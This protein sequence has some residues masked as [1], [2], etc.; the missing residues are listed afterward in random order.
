[1]TEQTKNNNNQNNHFFE[2]NFAYVTGEGDV[3][4]KETKLFKER[5]LATVEPD[6]AKEQVEAFEK[7]FLEL[8]S[9][10]DAFFE[11]AKKS[12]GE[13]LDKLKSDFD[14]LVKKAIETDAIGDFEN[15]IANAKEKFEQVTASE[16]ESITEDVK[17]ED[18][19][20][21]QESAE[22]EA[23]RTVDAAGQEPEDE[24]DGPDK[25]EAVS[26]RKSVV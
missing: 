21:Q 13:G 24:T 6:M 26:D 5:T 19:S 17:P 14:S 22:T 20:V 25:K 7:A 11:D 2:N 12:A 16:K 1:M 3:I 4:L 18:P 9:A 15:L 10:F 8:E 23:E